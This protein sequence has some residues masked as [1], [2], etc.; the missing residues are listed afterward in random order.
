MIFNPN[1]PSASIY[2]FLL[3]FYYELKYA[4]GPRKKFAAPFD[5]LMEGQTRFVK[6]IPNPED[7]NKV[8]QIKDY[9]KAQKI[10][11]V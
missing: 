11:P 1:V 4:F 10:R 7:L 8:K 2:A 6:R 3:N 5:M 9:G